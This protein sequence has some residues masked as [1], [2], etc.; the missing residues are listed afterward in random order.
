MYQLKESA[1]LEKN[2]GQ[3]EWGVRVWWEWALARN[4]NN[5]N[6]IPSESVVAAQHSDIDS[7]MCSLVTEVRRQNANYVLH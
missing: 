7:F 5:S 3:T 4:C 6:V 2:K 1:L